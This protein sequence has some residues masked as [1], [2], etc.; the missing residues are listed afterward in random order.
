MFNYQAAL[1]T[2]LPMQKVNTLF[3]NMASGR[4]YKTDFRQLNSFLWET[5]EAFFE[6][7]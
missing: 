7:I 4:Q 3:L 2:G 6:I 1:N 5:K